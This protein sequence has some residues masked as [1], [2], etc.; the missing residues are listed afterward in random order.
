MLVNVSI[1]PN[2]TGC[3]MMG[4]DRIKTLTNLNIKSERFNAGMLE[5][6]GVKSW[7]APA[8]KMTLQAPHSMTNLGKSW[9]KCYILARDDGKNKPPQ[10]QYL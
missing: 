7:S 6:V 8:A 3:E 4:N 1:K 10:L 2:V 9:V 5:N